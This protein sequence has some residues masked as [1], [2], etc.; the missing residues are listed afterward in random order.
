MRREHSLCSIAVV[1]LLTISGCEKP[2][3]TT[4]GQDTSKLG[5]SEIVTGRPAEDCIPSETGGILTCGNLLPVNWKTLKGDALKPIAEK[6]GLMLTDP[7][8]RKAL[9][10][11][12]RQAD[13]GCRLNGTQPHRTLDV[14]LR[15][16][17][18]MD[19]FPR[20]GTNGR[21]LVISLF[22][23]KRDEGCPEHRYA[24]LKKRPNSRISIEFTTVVSR[25]AL[26]PN[27]QN[28][29]I[30]EW[31]SWALTWKEKGQKAYE[32]QYLDK[33]GQWRQCGHTHPDTVGDVAFISCDAAE[34][35][36]QIARRSAKRG[37]T[38]QSLLAQFMGRD[39][40]LMAQ[41]DGDP[42]SDAA[43]GRCGS[44]GCCASEGT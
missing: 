10:T 16:P 17:L 7:H 22:D 2:A 9:K 34:K 20:V 26:P 33:T 6:L 30:G 43:W 42:F 3:K 11:I 14:L 12:T 13:Q 21:E 44:L 5:P 36:T 27:G 25:N 19:S 23:V 29:T 40:T 24:V 35:L 32:L 18:A 31:R 38:F 37:V 1:L 8:S 41:T 28:N 15:A 39:S 4:A